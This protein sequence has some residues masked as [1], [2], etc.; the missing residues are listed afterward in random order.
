[1]NLLGMWYWYAKKYRKSQ[2]RH[3]HTLP[4][5]VAMLPGIR[6]AIPHLGSEADATQRR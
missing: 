5:E 6:R 4:G 3:T 2:F 1:M